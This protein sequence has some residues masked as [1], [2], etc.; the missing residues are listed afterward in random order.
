MD[1]NT[2]LAYQRTFLA[3]EGTQM[4]WIRTAL[5]LISFGFTISKFFDNLNSKNNFGHPFFSA[6][7]VGLSMIFIGFTSLLLSEVLHRK[8]L[9]QLRKE[10]PDLPKSIAGKI[11]M[12]LSVLSILAFI[13]AIKNN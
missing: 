2:R 8:S 12:L 4:A 10:C 5:S 6:Q 3:W 7:T 13:G 9:V 11:S 1:T